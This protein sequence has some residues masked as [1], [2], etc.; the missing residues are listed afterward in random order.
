MSVFLSNL[1]IYLVTM[2][3]IISYVS[4]ASIRYLFCNFIELIMY[5]EKTIGFFFFF[6]SFPI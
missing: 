4:G 2:I 3:L 1:H 6:F 5:L